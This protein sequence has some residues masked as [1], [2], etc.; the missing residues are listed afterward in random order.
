MFIG[1]SNLTTFI[2]DLSSLTNG[3]YMFY[4][5]S[6]LTT[7]ISDLSS[8]NSGYCM[9]LYCK[10]DTDSL[11]H[12]AETINT[13][14]H[15]PSIHI[16]I[17]SKTPSEEEKELLTEIHNKGWQVYIGCNGGTSSEFIPTALT[18]IDGEEVTTPIPY[19]A[20][21]Q[22]VDEEHAEYTD[23][24]GKFYIILGGNYI[25]V[26]DPETYGLFTSL[27]DAAANMRLTKIEKT[28]IEKA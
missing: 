27:E 9:F 21:P 17:G 19:W 26:D 8:L 15:S 2:S 25:F 24:N 3:D 28:K 18:P 16:G 11:I 20:K 5:C 23:G 13:V 7:F 12:I 10:L 6:K 1:C 22:E 4:N 14:T